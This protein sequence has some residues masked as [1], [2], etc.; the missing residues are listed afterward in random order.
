M[1]FFRPLNVQVL[2]AI[3]LA[4]VLGMPRPQSRGNWL[5]LDV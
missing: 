5:R 2:V 4:V 3:V 1:A